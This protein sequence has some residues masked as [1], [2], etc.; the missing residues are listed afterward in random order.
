VAVAAGAK[1]ATLGFL[2][3]GGLATGAL[4]VRAADLAAVGWVAG[5]AV[6]GGWLA[7]VLFYRALDLAGLARS[8][9]VRAAAPLATAAVA[10]PFFPVALSPVNLAGAAVL[11]VACM[12]L[13]L[14]P[15]TGR[16]ERA[17]RS[18]PRP[19]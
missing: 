11:A 18:R 13:G 1:L 15:R 5:G 9:A 8:S 3:A 10:W 19:A 7:L 17:G 6:L 12:G 4:G 2:L 16:T 14:A